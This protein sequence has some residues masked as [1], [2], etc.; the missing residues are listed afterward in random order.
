MKGYYFPLDAHQDAHRA[1]VQAA[2]I[3]ARVRAQ[4]VSR[5]REQPSRRHAVADEKYLRM[6]RVAEVQA[7]RCVLLPEHAAG[8]CGAQP[9]PVRRPTKAPAPRIH[10]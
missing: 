3:L 2:A 7:L 5:V 4:Y 6:L 10:E 9:S 1:V 8:Q